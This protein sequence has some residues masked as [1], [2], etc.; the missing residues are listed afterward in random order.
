MIFT[1]PSR[2]PTRR[3]PPISPRF[4]SR[5]CSTMMVSLVGE[6]RSMWWKVAI[7]SPVRRFSTTRSRSSS[8]GRNS[9]CAV[10]S[11]SWVVSSCRISYC[12]TAYPRSAP[13]NMN[14]NESR[15]ATKSVRSNRSGFRGSS[16][17]AASELAS[18]R[19]QS[20]RIGLQNGLPVRVGER[21]CQELID[22]L[23]HVP[24][25]RARPIGSPQHAVGHL[26]QARKV[27]QQAGGGTPGDVEPAAPRPP[28]EE[29]HRPAG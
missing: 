28:H 9:E 15:R 29:R 8:T 2:V 26:G 22:V 13:R 17:W 18:S 11:S 14:T 12:H 20:Q 7:G 1:S 6:N 21:E 10:Y 4:T 5:S 3:R 19:E 16:V 24:D 27:L 23:A 25:A